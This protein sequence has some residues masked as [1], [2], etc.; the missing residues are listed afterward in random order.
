MVVDKN[1][2]TDL[3]DDLRTPAGVG[4]HVAGDAAD[5]EVLKKA[6]ADRAASLVTALPTDA[7]N[8]Y[9]VLSARVPAARNC[10][11]SP[12]PRRSGPIGKLERAGADRVVSPL[13]SGAVKMARF[14]L[15]PHVEDF[16]ADRRRQKKAS[17]NWPTC[18]SPRTANCAAKRCPH[19]GSER[20]R[21]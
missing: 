14:M 21:G 12:G 20:R 18:R 3:P 15:N 9:V 19:S 6:G 16:L 7:E 8:I 1:A 2:D 17:W 13:A 10:K 4:L 5:D 11:S